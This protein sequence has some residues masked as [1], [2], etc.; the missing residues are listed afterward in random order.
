VEFRILGPLEIVTDEG[1]VTLHR[2]KE[3]ALLAYLLLHPNQLLPSERLIDELWNEHPPPTAPKILQNAVSQLRK[4]LGEGRIET[5]PPGY[6]FRLADGELDVQRFEQLARDGRNRDA[7]TLWRGPPLVDLREERFADDARRRLDELRLA[8]LEGRID[9]DIEAGRGAQ[10]VPE[11]ESLVAQHPLREH[12]HGQ[13]MRALYA[14]GRQADAL[15]AYRRAHRTL[16]DELGLEPGPQLQALERSILTQDPALAPRPAARSK[17]RAPRSRR[18]RILL[19]AVAGVV[20][21]VALVAG[22]LA[23]TGGDSATLLAKKNSLAAIDP[24]S[25]KVVGVVPIGDTPR[26]VAV[27]AGRVWAANA[28]EGTVSMIDPEHVRVM[29]TIGIGAAATDLVVADGQV[30]VAGGSDDKLVRLDAHSGGVLETKAISSDLAA[31][32]YAITAGDGAIWIGSG[33]TIYKLDPTA[34]RFEAKRRYVGNGINDVAVHGGSVWIVTSAQAVIRLGAADLRQRGDEALGVIPI[35]LAIAE[36]SVWVG[37]ENP[38]GPGAALFRLDEETARV[39]QTIV[40]GGTGY[41]PSVEVA[42][43]DGAIWAAT[44][45]TGEV[46]RV[47]IRTGALVARIRV[48]GHPTGIAFGAGRVW[49]T[50]S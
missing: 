25:N 47:D 7:L 15:E 41:P 19:V 22:I 45:D 24:D 14:A 50:V 10:L 12:M 28:G 43:G 33:D 30:W 40:F 16:S 36:G 18:P 23:A 46:Q 13:L 9:E 26:G 29:R 4:A 37:G 20:V 48:G 38:T 8:V 49:V 1:P 34:D 32:A 5:R 44:Y 17:S 35:S 39:L 11:L 2:G 3:Q 42:S 27:G 6:V 31:S 21:L